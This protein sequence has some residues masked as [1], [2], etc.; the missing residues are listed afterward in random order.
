MCYVTRVGVLWAYEFGYVSF[1]V[2]Y[3]LRFDR[4]SGRDCVKIREGLR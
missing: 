2:N 1:C 3:V 4:V